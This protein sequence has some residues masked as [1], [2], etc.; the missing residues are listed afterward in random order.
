VLRPLEI[1][2]YPHTQIFKHGHFLQGDVRDTQREHGLY[3]EALPRDDHVLALANIEHHVI[4]HVPVL[5][6]FDEQVDK[7]QIN[8]FLKH[9]NYSWTNLE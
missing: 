4:C 6:K 8:Q 1:I 2:R 9:C 3:R 5:K 7:I